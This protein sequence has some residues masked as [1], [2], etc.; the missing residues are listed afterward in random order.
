MLVQYLLYTPPTFLFRYPYSVSLFS[1]LLMNRLL[2]YPK[3]QL[4]SDKENDQWMDVD[5][6]SYPQMKGSFSEQSLLTHE[7]SI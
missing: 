3:A 4:H 7:P 2:K 1:G 6:S 5:P